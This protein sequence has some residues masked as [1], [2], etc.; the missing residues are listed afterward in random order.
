MSVAL[1][2]QDVVPADLLGRGQLGA[3][4]EVG[5]QYAEAPDAFG[6]GDGGVRSVHSLL[7]GGV[8]VGILGE[9]ADGR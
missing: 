8:Q 5:L 1:L 2:A 3:D 9:V 4:R 6:R 7:D